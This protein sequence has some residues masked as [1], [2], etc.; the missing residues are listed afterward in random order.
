MQDRD[1]NIEVP[2]HIHSRVEDRLHRT[3][4][5][6]VDEYVTYVL[7]EVLV[8]VE[9]ATTGAHESVDD[10]DVKNRLESLGYLDS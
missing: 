8:E 2:E 5:S 4:F 7:E 9:Q 1:P 10:E 6:S 3:S